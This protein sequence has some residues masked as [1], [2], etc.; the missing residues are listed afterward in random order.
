[1]RSNPRCRAP[2]RSAAG[3][4]ATLCVAPGRPP[5]CACPPLRQ[6]VVDWQHADGAA[7]LHRQ[8]PGGSNTSCLKSHDQSQERE[9]RFVTRLM[10]PRMP[11]TRNSFPSVIPRG[12]FTSTTSMT[13]PSRT[14]CNSDGL[15]FGWDRSTPHFR[16][17]PRF[18]SRRKWRGRQLLRRRCC[19][20]LRQP[21]SAA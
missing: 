3:Y 19:A 16:R 2:A 17:R 11:S 6:V 5:R 8:W 21:A 9:R 1:M 7:T 14:C 18:W 4:S 13:A 20:C 10:V 15:L 12:S